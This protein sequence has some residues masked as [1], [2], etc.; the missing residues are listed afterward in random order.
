[1]AAVVEFRSLE[2]ECRR[3]LNYV[4]AVRFHGKPAILLRTWVGTLVVQLAKTPL[5][6]LRRGL[7]FGGRNSE[8]PQTF[9][10]LIA[11]FFSFWSNTLPLVLIIHST[12]K[13]TSFP[14]NRSIPLIFI[15]NGSRSSHEETGSS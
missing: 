3:V 1:M 15:Q 11:T 14:P 8:G 4:S 9:A 12:A 6:Q 2:Y 10:Y 13:T 5:S 7:A